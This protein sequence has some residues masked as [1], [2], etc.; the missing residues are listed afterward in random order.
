MELGSGLEPKSGTT[1]LMTLFHEQPSAVA[2]QV[3]CTAG[4]GGEVLNPKAPVALW[5]VKL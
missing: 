1:I 2:G 3:G 4:F 5:E